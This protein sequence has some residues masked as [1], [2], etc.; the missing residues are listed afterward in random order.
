MLAILLLAAASG[1]AN[2]EACPNR[3]DMLKAVKAE[4]DAIVMEI[5]QFESQKDPDSILL[6]HSERIKKVSD[7]LCGD[8]L[9]SDNI[10][11]ICRFTVR[12]WTKTVYKTAKLSWTGG[13]WSISESLN[14][15][16]PKNRKR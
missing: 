5:T 12:Y 1:C 2:P 13:R 3:N 9:P 8:P 7:I 16:Q 11:V 15:E 6:I 4:D 10:V 14:I